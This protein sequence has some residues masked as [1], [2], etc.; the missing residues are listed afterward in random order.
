MAQNRSH[1]VL[2]VHPEKDPAGDFDL[3]TLEG[4]TWGMHDLY[5]PRCGIYSSSL[6][7]PSKYELQLLIWM[8][9]IHDVLTKVVPKTSLSLFFGILEQPPRNL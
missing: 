9:G 3:C 1:F 6:E 8:R 5:I 7:Q 4:L 2:I